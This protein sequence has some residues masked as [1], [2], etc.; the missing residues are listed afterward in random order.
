MKTACVTGHRPDRLLGYDLNNV[1]WQT[2]KDQF[3]YL[4]TREGIERAITGMA[5]GTDMVFAYAVFELQDEGYPIKLVAAIPC[6]NQDAL[7]NEESKRMFHEILER[8]DEVVYV[9]E[10]EYTKGCLEARNRYMVDNSDEVIS[11]WDGK[12]KGGTFHCI[13]YA[14]KVGKPIHEI[15]VTES[16]D[17]IIK[18]TSIK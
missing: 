3:K 13:S 16:F 7:W 2:L 14:K 5:L 10:E 6:K 1:G 8:A 11:V 18:Y 4:L 15:K 12:P 17:G 9:S